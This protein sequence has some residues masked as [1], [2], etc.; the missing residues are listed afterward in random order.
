MKRFALAIALAC[1]LSSS[2]MAGYIP[3]TGAPEPVPP[4]D[5]GYIPSTGAAPSPIVEVILTILGIVN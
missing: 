2:A 1:V 5:P 4:T 3:S